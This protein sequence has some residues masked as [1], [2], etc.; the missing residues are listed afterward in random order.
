MPTEPT[1]DQFRILKEL[2]EAPDPSTGGL[3]EEQLAVRLDMSVAE[4]V[5]HVQ[6]LVDLGFLGTPPQEVPSPEGPCR[7]CGKPAD[8]LDQLCD[9]CRAI[10]ACDR[11]CDRLTN[12]LENFLDDRWAPHEYGKPRPAYY[13]QKPNFG[14]DETECMRQIATAR[15][16]IAS[17]ATR[18]VKLAMGPGVRAKAEAAYGEP[19]YWGPDDYPE[20]FDGIHAA[21]DW[22]FGDASTDEPIE[23]KRVSLSYLADMVRRHEVLLP[24]DQIPDEPLPGDRLGDTYWS[25]LTE[26]G[27]RAI[28]N[29]HPGD[30]GLWS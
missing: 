5:D 23:S 1:E 28:E 11:L 10:W 24:G 8:G 20:E 27:R 14:D 15:L 29:M 17:A 2:A 16:Q 30:P 7:R 12:A 18:L 19:Y 6:A 21:I 3:S 13:G 4:V 9:P 26:E 22:G 25:G